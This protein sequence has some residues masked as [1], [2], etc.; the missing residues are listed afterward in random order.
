MVG[1]NAVKHCKIWYSRKFIEI[2][3][4][5]LFLFMKNSKKSAVQRVKVF[6][7]LDGE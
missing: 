7:Q 5:K 2:R 3:F 4:N 1:K 6:K